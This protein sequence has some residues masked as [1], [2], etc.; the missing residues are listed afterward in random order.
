VKR[1]AASRKRIS[2]S[3]IIALLLFAS[4]WTA[5]PGFVSAQQ[6]ADASATAEEPQQPPTLSE[7]VVVTGSLSR[8]PV[9]ALA[10]TVQVIGESAIERSPATSV[11]ELLAEHG[12]GFMGQW[13]P[14]QTSVSIRGAQNDPQGRDF[15]SQIVVLVNGRRSGTSNLSKISL[16]DLRRVEIVRGASSLLYGSQ[17]VGGVINLILKDGINAGGLEAEVEGG[18][19][20]L[21]SGS[22][23]WGATF[24]R[25]D[26]RVSGHAARQGD[27]ESGSGSTLPMTN[28]AWEQRGAAFSIGYTRSPRERLALFLRSDGMYDAGF[29]GSAWDTDNFE[30]REN[31]S[32]D[33]SYQ[34]S[35]AD[36]RVSLLVSGYGYRDIDDFHWGSELVRNNQNRAV[37]GF[38]EDNNRRRNTGYGFKATGVFLAAARNTIWTGLDGDWTN[39]RSTRVRVPLPGAATTQ[40]PP[41]DNNSD[42]RNLGVFAESSQKLA[43]DRLTVRGGLRYDRMRVAILETPNFPTLLPRTETSDSVTYRAGIVVRAAP[44]THVRFGIGSGFRAPTATELAADFTA[45]QGGQQVGNPDLDPERSRNVEVGV[46][47]TFGRAS[48]DVVLFHT[49][50]ND[51]I[52]LTPIDGNR[53]MWSNR[54]TS[55]ITGLEVQLRSDLVRAPQTRVFGGLT[56]NYHFTMRDNE[57]ERLGLMSDRIQ[58]MYEYQAALRVGTEVRRLT[59]QLV[60][61]LHGPMWYDTEESLLVPF[62]EPSRTFVHRKSPFWLLTLSGEYR[63]IEGVLVRG[64]VTNLLDRNVHPTFIAENRE[65]FLSDPEFSLGGRGNSLPGRAFTVGLVFRP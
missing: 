65:P 12:V 18:S 49:D 34:R 54:G 27:Y 53:N 24:G 3:D 47:T 15:R 51:R 46:L 28:T 63:L 2:R 29:R 32:V 35:S 9:S 50:I 25:L 17:A 11:T 42:T 26:L 43:G 58:R 8:E 45:P 36:E 31:R 52:A 37:P 41:F 30:N 56:G 44:Q 6:P 7:E 39:L 55:D 62:A 40:I 59:A 38:D 61:T 16:D 13:T 10:S 19:F 21:A 22:A 4:A 33:L 20:G 23:G 64:A 14:A 57:A 48:A 1:R 5:A 60:S